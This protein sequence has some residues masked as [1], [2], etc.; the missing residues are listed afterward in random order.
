MKAEVP[1]S[2][3]LRVAL[4]GYEAGE[5]CSGSQRLQG[6]VYLRWG[7]K[8]IIAIFCYHSFQD[9]RQLLGTS[10]RHCWIGAIGS[11]ACALIFISTDP[12][13]ANGALPLNSS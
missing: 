4:R 9:R 3:G 13:A 2:R 5:I 10:A 6:C 1:K 12:K 7:A 8:A 11:K